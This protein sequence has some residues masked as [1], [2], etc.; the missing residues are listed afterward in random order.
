MPHI[1]AEYTESLSVDMAKLLFD[2][3]MDLSKRDTV[4]IHAIKTRA[5]PVKYSIVGDGHE[6]DKFIHI[7]L[8]L[9]PGRDEA[10]KKQM[11]QGLFDVARKHAHDPEIS[12]SVEIVTLEADSYMKG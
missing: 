11:T 8:K 7:M 12:V 3:H 4:N 2:L 1:V 6:P 5:I 9:L 10:L